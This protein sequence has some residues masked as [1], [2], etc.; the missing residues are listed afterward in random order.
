M[1]NKCALLSALGSDC[2]TVF[3]KKS[4]MAA[5]IVLFVAE[6]FRVRNTPA[7]TD[8]TGLILSVNQNPCILLTSCIVLDVTAP[9]NV[10]YW[11]Y[12]L[13]TLI[14]PKEDYL[15]CWRKWSLHITCIISSSVP[16]GIFK[17]QNKNSV[18]WAKVTK[19]SSSFSSDKRENF[20]KNSGVLWWVIITI[21]D[22]VVETRWECQALY[23]AVLHS[24]YVWC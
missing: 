6:Y 14:I 17:I 24:P 9:N 2:T 3:L 20:D 5:L 15:E 12:A 10:L 19:E 1:A 7:P 22:G 23:F 13:Y 8:L 18:F 21:C 4:C 16:K 11:V